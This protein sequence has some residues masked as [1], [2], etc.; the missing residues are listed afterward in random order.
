MN[1]QLR[2]WQIQIP[3]SKESYFGCSLNDEDRH[4]IADLTHKQAMFCAHYIENLDPA[5]AAEMA[6][7]SGGKAL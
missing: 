1:T 7:L 5:K 6:L 4:L 3:S 2:S